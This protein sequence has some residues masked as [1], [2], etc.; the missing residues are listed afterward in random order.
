MTQKSSLNHIAALTSGLFYYDLFKGSF[1]LFDELLYD[2]FTHQQF[3]KQTAELRYLL[4]LYP[5]YMSYKTL[6]DNQHN[7]VFMVTLHEHTHTRSKVKDW[8]QKFTFLI[9]DI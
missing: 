4:L 6:E 1:C 7:L 5:G 9:V 8:L 2:D 3:G